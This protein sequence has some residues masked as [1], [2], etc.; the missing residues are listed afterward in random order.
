MVRFG[1]VLG[2][3]TQNKESLALAYSPRCSFRDPSDVRSIVKSSRFRDWKVMWSVPWHVWKAN[4][5]CCLMWLDGRWCWFERC[6]ILLCSFLTDKLL[7]YADFKCQ[8]SKFMT[9]CETTPPLIHHLLSWKAASF[10]TP[11]VQPGLGQ[12]EIERW[13]EFEGFLVLFITKTGLHGKWLKIHLRFWWIALFF[14]FC[15]EWCGAS[16]WCLLSI[17]LKKEPLKQILDAIDWYGI[18]YVKQCWK[19]TWQ[20]LHMFSR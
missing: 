5:P 1:I 13:R 18:D 10:R 11:Q 2:G 19:V 4:S 6:W 9:Y 16:A 7:V 15:I 3:S 17:S 20:H 8:S 14:I 12:G